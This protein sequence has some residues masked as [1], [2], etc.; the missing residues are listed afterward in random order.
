MAQSPASPFR[1][2]LGATLRLAGPL[3]LAN[4]LQMSVYATD[5]I[6]IA[7]LGTEPLAAASLTT[8]LL[9]LM[10]WAFSG[11]TGAAAPLIAAELG[12]GR[13]AVRQV[14]R[15]VRMALWLA[16]LC[17]A[18]GLAVCQFGEAM[19][20]A[21]GQQAAIAARAGPFMAILGIAILPQVACNVLRIYVAALGRPVVATVII[22]LAI[23]VNV[24]GNYILVFGHFGAPRLGLEG[25]AWAT[26]ITSFATLAA[27]VLVIRFSRRLGRYRI[28]GRWWRAEWT[29]LREIL[30][31]GLPI[32]LIVLAEGGFFGA[33]A[34]LMGM[35]GA[36]Q[37]AAHTIALQ[38][39]ALFF[40]IPFGIAQAAT[41]RVGF[42]FGA[43]DT[44]GVG[45]AGIAA[46]LTCLLFQMAGAGVMLFAPRLVLSAYIDVADAANAQV[47]AYA[48]TYLMV[49]AAFQ[50][51]DGIQAVAAG[52]LRGLQD[53]RQPM[54]I[55]L[56]G[57]WLVGFA[58]AAT[59]A[60]TTELQGT[61]VWIGLAVGLVV[62]AG[63]LLLR[64]QRRAVLGL[65]SG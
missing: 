59:L 12:R 53:T 60:F 9:G 25:S 30:R 49:A 51:F 23:A 32:G 22:A 48:V 27:Y 18:I 11:L 1:V 35:I 15:T 52:L 31:I 65:L 28:F 17:G 8:A 55:A 39:A 63:L 34:F 10:V 5:V 19:L 21:L 37:L 33:A 6:F 3:A 14:R 20:L 38:V 45:R 4:L 13:H 57:Y 7:R 56:F 2:E 41:I 50:L 62:V 61:G 36:P 46:L 29:R 40:Q 24:L 58:T 47:V 54:V 26:V 16:V 42:H 64:W 43:G 44:A